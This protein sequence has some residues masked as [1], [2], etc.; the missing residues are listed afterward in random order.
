MVIFE[1]FLFLDVA[2]LFLKFS[3]LKIAYYSIW[4]QHWVQCL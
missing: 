2:L 4:Y 1:G 3:A